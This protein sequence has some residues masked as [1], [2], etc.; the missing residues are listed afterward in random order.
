MTPEPSDYPL[1]TLVRQKIYDD[2]HRCGIVFKK[3][4][5]ADI[6]WVYWQMNEAA[7]AVSNESYSEAVLLN[8]LRPEKYLNIVA[9]PRDV[10]LR[11]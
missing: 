8:T 2:K 5:G 1:G 3:V 9:L 7:H 11:E 10:D 6:I 4:E